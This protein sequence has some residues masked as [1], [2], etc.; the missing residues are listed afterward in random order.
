MIGVLVERNM[1]MKL[2]T[3]WCGGIELVCSTQQRS[4]KMQ[5]EEIRQYAEQLEKDKVAQFGLGFAIQCVNIYERFCWDNK[6][7]ERSKGFSK[8]LHASLKK[9][10]LVEFDAEKFLFDPQETGEYHFAFA[11]ICLATYV[12]E[13][14]VCGIDNTQNII[15]CIVN[16]LFEVASHYHYGTVFNESV[17]L[18][19][20]INWP[21]QVHLPLLKGEE[22]DKNYF[23]HC[24]LALF[25]VL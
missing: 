18:P 4:F 1:C 16:E 3:E 6:F 20:H 25:P 7:P 11:A 8:L 5:V 15:S 14:R 24:N 2:Y 22:P 12:Y 17:D 19:E 13:Q 9:Q 21:M 23:I 10:A